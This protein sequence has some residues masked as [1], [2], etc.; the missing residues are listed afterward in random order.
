M[1]PFVGA[2]EA[3]GTKF[4]CAYGHSP[5]DLVEARIPTTTPAETLDRVAQWFLDCGV[6]LGALGIGAFGP[7]ELDPASPKWGWITSTPKPGWRDTDLAG[8]LRRRLGVPVGFETDVN[9][10]ALGERRWGAGAGCRD[11]IYVTVGTGI[12]GGVIA[13]GALVHG[14]LHPELG[15]IRLPHDR[16]R[17]PFP[18]LC[19]YHGDCL[20]GLASG[21][22]MQARWGQPAEMLPPDHPAWTLQAEY[23]ALAIGNWICC[24]S[25]R[26]V[27]LGGGV[28]QG[29]GEALLAAIRRRVPALLAGYLDCAAI[30]RDI[31]GYIVPPGLG[32]RSG[33]L[34][35]LA[36]AEAAG[37]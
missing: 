31:D 33:I 4:V 2:I 11:F 17:D 7:V 5:D 25:P 26:R 23:L 10:A 36:L 12:G 24:F 29:G 18:G 13:G 9:A 19:P 6:P 30:R 22:A 27:I 37:G 15:H 35:A 1:P 28:M 8:E 3:G 14:L 21:P 32:S 20:E 34:G 16:D